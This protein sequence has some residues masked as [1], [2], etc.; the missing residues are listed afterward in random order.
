MF[1]FLFYTNLENH[2]RKNLYFYFSFGHWIKNSIFKPLRRI[3]FHL[4]FFF[5]K[6]CLFFIVSE[7][8][9]SKLFWSFNIRYYQ[10]SSIHWN[11]YSDTSSWY[12]KKKKNSLEILNSRWFSSSFS[13]VSLC[14]H[15][16]KKKNM[17]KKFSHSKAACISRQIHTKSNH[18]LKMYFC[19]LINSFPHIH[20]FHSYFLAAWLSYII[21][22]T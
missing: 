4:L 3:S 18:I 8:F 6:H 14:D 20:S 9:I 15:L 12:C 13:L 16:Q 2:A 1:C 5:F 19:F 7:Y 11:I 10:L 17:R 21:E 22:I